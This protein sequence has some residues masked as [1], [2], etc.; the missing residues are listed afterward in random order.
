MILYNLQIYKEWDGFWADV[1]NGSVGVSCFPLVLCSERVTVCFI[2][3]MY[4]NVTS[5]FPVGYMQ[6][7]ISSWPYKNLQSSPATA[8][9][10]VGTKKFRPFF[11][12]PSL[13]EA[14]KQKELSFWLSQ[15]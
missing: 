6:Y 15:L 11:F 14:L 12:F 2:F 10:G 13:C 1:L 4:Q 9:E 5:C 7:S 8:T 3:G